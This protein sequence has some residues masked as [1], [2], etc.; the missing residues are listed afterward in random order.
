MD[1]DDTTE[2][3]AALRSLLG[4]VDV[5]V[6]GEDVDTPVAG[7]RVREQERK[8]VEYLR[9][10]DSGRA[11]LCRAARGHCRRGY[12]RTARRLARSAPA[13]CARQGCGLHELCARCRA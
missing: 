10:H 5:F 2:S 13:R 1:G 4:G 7:V 6:V 9:S 11:S 12:G 8:R 3:I